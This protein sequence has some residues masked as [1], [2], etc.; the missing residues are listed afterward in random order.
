M[1]ECYNTVTRQAVVVAQLVERSLPTQEYLGLNPAIG[2]L[3]ISCIEK[4]KIK[5]KGPGMAHFYK[6]GR[7]RS[8]Q[9]INVVKWHAYDLIWPLRCLVNL[10]DKLSC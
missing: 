9:I 2:K 3:C 8:L 10:A 5:K 7:R 1:G 6:T 4:R